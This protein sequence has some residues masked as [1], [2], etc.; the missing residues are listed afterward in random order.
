MGCRYSY[1]PDIGKYGSTIGT[2]A[3]QSNEVIPVVL[4]Q[5]RIDRKVDGTVDFHAKLTRG[6]H[7]KLTH[8]RFA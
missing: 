8:P 7:L 1:L 4:Q 3:A 6:F 5:Y 2:S